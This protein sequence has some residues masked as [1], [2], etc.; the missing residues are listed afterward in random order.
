MNDQ[1]LSTQLQATIKTCIENKTPIQITAGNSKSFYG[2]N[3]HGEALSVSAHQ[4]IIHYEPTELVITARCGTPLTEIEN[5]L[6]AHNQMLGFEPPH[7]SSTATLG[8]CVASGLSGPARPYRGSV[9]DFVLG[10][11]II[12][13]K[14]ERLNF[15]G[16]VM[17]NVAGYDVSRLMAGA[18]GT[19]G[20]ILDVSMK[21][22]PKP[23]HEITLGFELSEEAAISRINK[24]C[25]QSLPITAACYD[26]DRLHVR[27][28]GT[29]EGV[30][31]AKTL[32]GGELQPDN[33]EFWQR[34]RE[35]T[36]SFFQ[37][38]LPLWRCAVAPATEPLI[39]EGKQFIDWGG[40]QR[41]LV[42]EEKPRT[43]FNKLAKLEGHAN[44]FRNGDRDADI[45]QPLN[46]KLYQLHKQVKHAFDPHNLFN[47]GR[48][49]PDL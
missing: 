22:L 27:L 3:V 12:N 20:I 36:H 43:I 34:I 39:F 45:F 26:G 30:S 14:A 42:G 21:V 18:M 13:G 4:G 6:N 28:S 33:T 44:I 25:G 48:L 16:E 46:G 17:K 31:A 32:L 24:Y 2:R 11:S 5:T 8:G 9:R 15:G 40:A 1:D 7:F 10:C 23:E 29:A 19:L 47:P 49:Y 37:S 41:W 38:D 35:Q